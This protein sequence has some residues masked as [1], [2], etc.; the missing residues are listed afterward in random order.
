MVILWPDVTEIR[1][2]ADK[3]HIR[4]TESKIVVDKQLGDYESFYRLLRKHAPPF[5]WKTLSLPLQCRAGLVIP[6]FFCAA[7][8]AWIGLMWWMVDYSPPQNTVDL[9]TVIFFFGLGAIPLPCGLYLASFR[10]SFD[11]S[12]IRISSL[13]RRRAYKVHNLVDL[14]LTSA[15][16]PDVVQHHPGVIMAALTNQQFEFYFRTGPALKLFARGMAVDPE[17][18]YHL[19]Q[20]SYIG[21]DESA[22]T[23]S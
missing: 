22:G 4:S 11:F 7:G 1:S 23:K 18:L 15:G 3:V 8:M 2:T 13:A 9:V 17:A 14:K 10:Y 19:L 12:E 5:A 6:S 21:D 20:R 16:V